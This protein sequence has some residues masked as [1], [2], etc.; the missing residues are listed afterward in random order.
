MTPPSPKL[1]P[2]VRRLFR[3]PQN[4]DRL[5]HEMDEEV[6]AHLAM[7]IDELCALGMS[8]ADAEREARRRFGD[9]EEF[10]AYTTQR[11]ARR[12]RRL[13][14]SRWLTE[15]AQDVRVAV[16]QLRRAPMLAVLVVGTLALCIGTTTA[17]YSV[18]RYRLLAPLP[19]PDGDRIVS[20]ATRG[21]DEGSVIHFGVAT[22]LFRLWAT[23][24]RTLQDVAAVASR[25]YAVADAGGGADTADVELVTP[26]FLPM[27][28]VGPVLGRGFAPADARRG[29][30]PVAMIGEA[31]WRGRY[32]AAR[33]VIGRSMTVNGVPRTIVG[34]VPHEAGPPIDPD[35][36]AAAVWLPLNVDSAAHVSAF[37]RLRPGVTSA[38]A[39]REL[40][41]LTRVLPDTGW[42]RERR[43]EA[44]T[45]AERVE[46]RHR[47]A[48]EAM[49]AVTSGLLLLACADVAGLLL[50]RGWA[51]RRE[52]AI[53]R[54]LG[55]WRGR[56]ARQLLTESLLLALPSGALGL[57]VAWLARRAAIASGGGPLGDLAD[58]PLDTSVVVWTAAASVTTALLFGVGP[59]FLAG[60]QPLDGALRTGGG[61]RRRRGGAERAHAALVIGQIALSLVLLAGAGVLARSFVALVRTPVGYE[62][63]GLYAAFLERPSTPPRA[64]GGP[65]FPQA[66]V[67]ADVARAVREA[68]GATPGIREVAVGPMPLT[69]IQPGPTAVEGT[70]GVRPVVMPIVVT[71]HVGREYF[72]VAG[73]R[74][75]RG[76]EL[77]MDDAGAAREVVVN[78]TLARR[79]WPDRD[80]LGARLRIGDGK[81][82]QWLTVVGVADDL[83][84]PGAP[85][86]F[87]DLQLYRAAVGATESYNALV[88]RA[89]GDTAALRPLLARAVERAGVGLTVRDVTAARWAL[90]YAYRGPRVTLALFGAFALLAVGLAA[91]G[92]FGI[93]AYAV[94]RRTREIGVRV[95]L[96]ADP[97]ALTRTIL[98][99]SLRLI[100]T[101]CGVGV[102]GAYAA[103]HALTALVYG[104]SPAD[105]VALGGAVALLVV[106]ALAAAALPVRRALRVDPSDT[107]R[108][109]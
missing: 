68:L 32:G 95:A 100:A 72:R 44:R 62:P 53:R 71:S 14:V 61:E 6:E 43:A 20:L 1:P 58:A 28:R 26:S 102:L 103:S 15:G 92:L 99:R 25:R 89:A 16:R 96:G 55:A 10:R 88:L 80:A 18:V 70:T 59:A 35:V 78:A 3:L 84:M 76:R 81:D 101:G 8:A 85:E 45:A 77:D 82:A 97:G 63:A 39:S 47:R 42:L 57:A 74:L 79:L 4:R 21:P 17:S 46:P 54:A 73:I 69:N 108:A 64:L 30:P 105:P 87:F 94:A 75:R 56:L 67:S 34:V 51:R 93:V 48:V 65:P 91:V 22:E 38:D 23:R 19:Y 83:R 12:A 31:V 98:G 104:V 7:R 90:E 11:A 106:V 13:A 29:A 41:A 33:E 66:E 27:L 52:F 86:G 36:Q 107:L 40:Q 49:F 24:S 109:E 2:S 5:R 60:R 37:A 9:A 50:M